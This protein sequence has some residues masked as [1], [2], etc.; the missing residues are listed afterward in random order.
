MPEAV[1]GAGEGARQTTAV[2]LIRAMIAAANA[3]G[4]IDAQE[5]SQILDKLKTVEL[6]REEHQFIVHELLE[7]KELGDIIKAVDGMEMA[8]QVYAASL[9]AITVDTPAEEE[10]LSALAGQLGLDVDTV[11]SI[12]QQLG[13]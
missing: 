13:R 4:V 3:D 5:R 12:H 6:S 10:Y 8:R 11:Q 9:L 2:L 7:P 1:S